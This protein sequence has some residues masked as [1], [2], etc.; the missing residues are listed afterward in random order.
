MGNKLKLL[1][2]VGAAIGLMLLAINV[3]GLFLPLRSPEINESYSDFAR[4]GTPSLNDSLNMLKL[5]SANHVPKSE[6]LKEA[7]R[8][9]HYGIA[10][11]PKEDI[12]KNGFDYY[13]M[14]VPLWENYIL[15][16]L[17]Y[18]K[19][20][21]YRDY[22]FCS[23]QKALER[24]TGRC[25]QQSLALVDYLHRNDIETGFIRLGGHAIATAKAEDGTWYMLDPDYGGVIPFG[26]EQAEAEPASVI[27]YYWGPAITTNNMYLLF[28]KEQ[29]AIRYGGPEARF[30]RACKIE[31]A[32]YALKWAIPAL[33]ILLWLAYQV[34]QH[35]YAKHQTNIHPR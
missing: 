1:V 10:H 4:R 20:D 32:S 13:R 18:L 15:Y 8:I 23:Y 29:N 25:G 33:L 7:T 19:P 2:S 5:L 17:S 26:L 14:R 30:G 16:L 34:R 21:T 27:P 11:I 12:E 35:I 31:R 24:G 9:F 3:V 22:E 6:F 28:G